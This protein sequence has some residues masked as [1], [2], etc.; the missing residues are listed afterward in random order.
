MRTES[1]FE[2]S[3]LTLEQSIELTAQ[4]LRAYAERYAH[5]AIA[6]SGGKDSSALVSVVAGFRRRQIPSVGVLA[7]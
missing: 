2:R 4:S 3:R 6:Y 7:S 1:L 5:W